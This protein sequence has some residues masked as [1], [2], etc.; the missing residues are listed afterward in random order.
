MPHNHLRLAPR[1]RVTFYAVFAVLFAS[2][3]GWWIA[4]ILHQ[5]EL[6]SSPSQYEPWL[7]KVHGAAALTALLVLGVIYP[8]HVA[9]SWRMRRNVLWGIVL[10]VVAISLILTGYF[11]YYAGG[12]L[13]RR[14]ASNIHIYLGLAFPIFVGVHVWRGRAS[15][16]Q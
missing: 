1:L 7:L 14:L 2:G 12:E 16:R 5:N 4:H 11:L 3:A 15:R 9:R 6:E 13:S 10:V 8:V